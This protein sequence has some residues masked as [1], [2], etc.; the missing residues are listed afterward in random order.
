MDVCASCLDIC[1]TVS[2]SAMLLCYQNLAGA[3]SNCAR[4][5]SAFGKL[6][7]LRKGDR[8]ANVNLRVAIALNEACYRRATA[9]RTARVQLQ[10]SG[11]TTT[12]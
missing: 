5:R 10:S 1:L 4:G 11:E 9:S 2:Y 3:P 7:W 12:T 6:Y 8:S